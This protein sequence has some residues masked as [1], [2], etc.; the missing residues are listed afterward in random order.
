MNRNSFLSNGFSHLNRKTLSRAGRGLS[1]LSGS[2]LL[3]VSSN[4]LF[5]MSIS[6]GDTEMYVDVCRKRPFNHYLRQFRHVGCKKLPEDGMMTWSTA[7]SSKQTLES[8]LFHL[9]CPFLAFSILPLTSVY[10][11]PQLNLQNLKNNVRCTIPSPQRW[12]HKIHS[13]EHDSFFTTL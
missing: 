5:E 9:I 10:L 12:M 8:F 4:G 7:N 13:V 2:V 6:V 1:L 11:T 3:W